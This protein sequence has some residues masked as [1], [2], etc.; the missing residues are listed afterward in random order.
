MVSRVTT[1]IDGNIPK[2]TDASKPLVY[3][4]ES[5]PNYIRE[6]GEPFCKSRLRGRVSRQA[7]MPHRDDEDAGALAGCQ[8]SASM[9]VTTSRELASRIVDRPHDLLDE[10]TLLSQIG[11]HREI[12]AARR[13]REPAFRYSL[14]MATK[15]FHPAILAR[16]AHGRGA[17]SRT[18]V[19]PHMPKDDAARI[20][21]KNSA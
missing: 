5:I 7:K 15:G 1:A 6:R 16:R 14:G 9:N 21:I 12:E 11:L 18:A 8:V 13:H 17:T 3:V 19:L 10:A 20:T 4:A 2:K